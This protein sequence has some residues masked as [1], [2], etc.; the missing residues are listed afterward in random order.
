[1]H[2]IPLLSRR[3]FGRLAFGAAVASAYAAAAAVDGGAV[4][5]SASEGL[6]WGES[7]IADGAQPVIKAFNVGAD[8]VS[9]S[10]EGLLPGVKYN[11]K[12]GA[13]VGKLQNYA[14]DVPKIVDDGKTTFEINKSDDRFFSVVREPLAK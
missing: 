12:M 11:V 14:L 13:E 5:R 7:A 10:V 6:A 4:V 3:T 2:D 9:I 1:M 8:K